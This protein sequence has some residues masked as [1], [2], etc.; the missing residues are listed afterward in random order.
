MADGAAQGHSKTAEEEVDEWIFAVLVQG[1]GKLGGGR[2][3][4][5]PDRHDE[6]VWDWRHEGAEA[7]WRAVRHRSR[8]V[9]AQKAMQDA[10]LLPWNERCV[11][12]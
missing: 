8:V 6:E 1:A 2:R 5:S 9:R 10:R 12:G 4:G 7:I 3:R 11:V